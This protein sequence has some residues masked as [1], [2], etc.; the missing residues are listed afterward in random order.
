M[1][2]IDLRKLISACIDAT[3]KGGD[4]ARNLVLH[5]GGDLAIQ[6]KTG[7]TDLLT[8][9]DL[10]VQSFIT[11]SLLLHWPE[12][13]IIGEE[14][15]SKE[16]KN[17]SELDLTRL[18]DVEISSDTC[19]T[20]PLEDITLYVDPIDGTKEFTE[21]LYSNVTIL[22]GIANKNRPIAGVISQPWSEN[23]TH[24]TKGP[25]CWGLVGYG[26]IGIQPTIL[27]PPT[28]DDG[29]VVVVTRS[30]PTEMLQKGLERLNPKQ[31]LKVVGC[32]YKSLIVLQ[33][34]AHLYYYPSKGT[35][36]WDTCAPEAL[37]TSIGGS[38]T[39]IFGDKIDYGRDQPLDNPGIIV[40]LR[41]H[42]AIDE[43]LKDYHTTSVK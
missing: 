21:G 10:R 43:K 34:K 33:G 9:V 5:Q 2:T 27:P 36:K 14:D 18:N 39:D 37:L 15:T 3:D 1:T 6:E 22:I 28:D 41:G 35:S 24:A 32:G 4:L 16:E 13:H 30:H 26:V 23:N 38:V 11:G 8:M 20:Y 19:T 17:F 42:E 40:T 29:L 25:L 7:P 31:I 12:L